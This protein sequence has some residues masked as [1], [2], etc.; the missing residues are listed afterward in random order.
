MFAAERNSRLYAGGPELQEQMKDAGL[1]PAEGHTYI[2]DFVKPGGYVCAT[3]DR[4]TALLEGTALCDT[5]LFAFEENTEK[6]H[7]VLTRN[8]GMLLRLYSGFSDR[9]RDPLLKDESVVW[10]AADARDR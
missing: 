9:I 10:L 4:V 5:R 3:E 1:T 6:A 8:R 7:V 2:G